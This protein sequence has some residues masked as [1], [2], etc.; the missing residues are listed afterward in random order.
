MLLWFTA[1]LFTQN[2][3]GTRHFK[4]TT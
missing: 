4:V 2:L 3:N 1:K